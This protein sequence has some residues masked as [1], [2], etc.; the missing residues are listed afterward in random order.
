MSSSTEFSVGVSGIVTPEAVVLDFD[1]AGAGSRIL[2]E[3]V[4]LLIQ[5]TI[6]FALFF[7]AGLAASGG[8]ELGQ[9]AAIILVTVLTFLVLVGYPVAFESLWNGRT[10]GKAALGLRVV[11]VEGGPIRF[12]HAAIRGMF[13]LVEIWATAGSV[14]LISVVL[15][16]RNQRVGDLVAG[17]VVLR[18]RSATASSAEAT[19]VSFPP[20]PGFDAYVRALDVSMLTTEQYGLVRSFLLRVDGLS[21]E[22]RATLAVDL[23]NS[24]ATRLRHVPPPGMGPEAYLASVASAYQQRY[25]AVFRPQLHPHLPPPPAAWR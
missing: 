25:G 15:T 23:A 5:G 11:T 16:R 22:A 3:V 19:A 20:L 21:P 1:T 8:V 6:L 24:V 12:R 4:D 7:A 10:P 14:A 2:S 13:A 17:T 18:E 9:T